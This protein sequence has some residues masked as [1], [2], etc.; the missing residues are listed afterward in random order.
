MTTP[1]NA[2]TRTKTFKTVTDNLQELPA[3]IAKTTLPALKWVEMLEN[4]IKRSKANG[5]PYIDVDE[6]F[7][8]MATYTA[9]GRTLAARL[10]TIYELI[11]PADR[12]E[13]K[14]GGLAG[15]CTTDRECAWKAIASYIE[16]TNECYDLIG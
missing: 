7:L 6:T 13:G 8:K 10:A 2:T 4:K 14:C 11:L 16:M 15:K 3:M 9:N 5:R 12:N 1:T